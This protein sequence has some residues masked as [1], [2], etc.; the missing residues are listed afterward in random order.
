[1]RELKSRL[2][3]ENACFHS[4]HKVL[5]FHLLSRN[6]KI[7]VYKIVILLVVLCVY[8]T[9]SLTLREEHKLRV[10]EKCAYVL[11]IMFGPKRDEVIG[12]WRKLHNE[13]LHN[14]YSAPN[15]ISVI[16]SGG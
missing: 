1:M 15:I 9:W 13:E 3:L 5:S 2:N 6:I 12:Y 10:F 11:R 16:K 8:E 7:E 14:L 4:V